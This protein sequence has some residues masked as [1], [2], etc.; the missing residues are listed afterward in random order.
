VA[1]A[2]NL[3]VLH[4]DPRIAARWQSDRHVVKMTLEAA[5]ILC[6]AAWNLGQ[7]APYRPTHAKH[8]CVQ[9]AGA[10]RGNWEWVVAHGLALA[11]EYERRFGRMHGSLPVLRWAARAGVGPRRK[12]RVR[13]QKFVMAL[14]DKYRGLD[15]VAAYRRY[16]RAEKASFATWKAPATPPPWWTPVRRRAQ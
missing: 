3:F 16:Y 13:R 5:Q 11:A 14:P 12:G 7:K 8:P 2:V 6:S 1:A 4:R 10:C 9:W 15:P